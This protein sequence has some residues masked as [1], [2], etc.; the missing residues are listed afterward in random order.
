[1]STAICERGIYRTGGGA[2]LDRLDKEL[3]RRIGVTFIV[4]PNPMHC[5]I[6]GT[7]KV[8]DQFAQREHLLIK[9]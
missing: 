7:R 9:P 8:L 6:E 2:L 1:M 4:P 3:T 5:V